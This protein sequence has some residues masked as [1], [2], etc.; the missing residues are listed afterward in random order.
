MAT[1]SK[2]PEL[3]TKQDTVSTPSSEPEKVTETEEQNTHPTKI[4]P[5]IN[6]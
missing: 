4:R 2:I 3:P 1:P 5:D 6:T